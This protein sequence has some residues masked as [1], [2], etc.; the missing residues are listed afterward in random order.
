MIV[1]IDGPAGANQGGGA[2]GS[3]LRLRKAEV[4]NRIAEGMAIASTLGE[5]AQRLASASSER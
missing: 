4:A 5:T 3:N 1:T 2:M